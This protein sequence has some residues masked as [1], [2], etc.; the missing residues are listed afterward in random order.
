MRF[1]KHHY[2][3]GRRAGYGWNRDWHDQRIVFTFSADEVPAVAEYHFQRNNKKDHPAGY[4]KRSLFYVEHLK[5]TVALPEKNKQNHEGDKKLTR[6]NQLVFFPVTA[7]KQ[8]KHK[9]HI[10]EGIYYYKKQNYDLHVIHIAA[11]LDWYRKKSTL[12]IHIIYD[13]N[14]L[15]VFFI[16]MIEDKILLFVIV[17]K[18]RNLRRYS[19]WPGHFEPRWGREF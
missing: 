14:T 15:Q 13:Y 17:R 10:A 5:D 9:R 3:N 4:I 16:K 19:N 8:R 18:D 12:C 1:E 7:L 2:G 6:D 11:S